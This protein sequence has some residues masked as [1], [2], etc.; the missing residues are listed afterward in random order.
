M[1]QC[2]CGAR[3]V[4]LAGFT[5]LERTE[6]A[7]LALDGHTARMRHRHDRAGDVD[8][9]LIGAGCLDF[10]TQRAVHHDRGEAELYGALTHGGGRTVILMHHQRDPRPRLE[11]RPDD[12]SQEIG[13]GVPA[14]T[15]RRL[16]DHR[17]V[18]L[19]SDFHDGVHLFHVVDVE[20][21]HA[22]VVLGS[23]IE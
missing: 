7:K 19:G 21:R 2:A 10:L 13:F 17:A 4:L 12:G 9:V 16:H 18:R 20:R 22:V 1:A 5:G 23:V 11:R 8:G 15:R 6:T 14:C 3:A